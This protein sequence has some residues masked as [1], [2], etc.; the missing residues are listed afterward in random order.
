[1][2]VASGKAVALAPFEVAT[3]AMP[4]R[5]VAKSKALGQRGPHMPKAKPPAPGGAPVAPDRTRRR[6]ERQKEGR[7]KCGDHPFVG[8]AA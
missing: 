6:Y 4:A 2:G 1:M 5:E 8:K 7:G 3:L